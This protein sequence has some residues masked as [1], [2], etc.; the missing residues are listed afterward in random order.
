LDAA[1][2]RAGAD[3]VESGDAR[4]GIALAVVAC[5]F[6]AWLRIQQLGIQI[7]VDDEWHALHKLLHAGVRDIAT[8]FG[9]ADYS[10]PLTLYYRGLYDLGL[11]DEWSMRLPLLAAGLALLVVAPMLARGWIGAEARALLVGLLAIA[12]LPV[13]YS[14]TARPYA[15][16]CVLG[17]VAIVAFRR[18]WQEEPHARRWALVYALATIV[19]GWLHL[20]SLVFT[21]LP[22]AYYGLHALVDLASPA[23]RAAG[24]RGVRRLLGLGCATA[25]PLAALLVPPLLG[26]WN[27]LAVKTASGVP[28]WHGLWRGV[29]MLFGTGIPAV[30]IVLGGV[31]GFGLLRVGCR[32]PDLAGYLAAIAL[33][34]C[35]VILAARP[36][37]IQHQAAFARYAL[38]VL[39]VL[40]LFVAEG[41]AGLF[42]GLRVRR[43]TIVAA[44]SAGVIALMFAAGPIPDRLQTPNQFT[45]HARYAFDFAAA[46]NPYLQPNMLPGAP[47]PAFY[48]ELAARPPESVT[49]I[50]A[51]WRLESNYVPE[52]YYQPIHRQFVKVGMVGG[53]CGTRDWGEYPESATGIHL[54]N[55]VHLAAILRGE[56]VGADYLIVRPRPWTIPPDDRDRIEWPDMGACLP[57]I[58]AALGA[59]LYRDAQIIVF[60]LPGS[61]RARITPGR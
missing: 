39:P 35:V 55:A 24:A 23:R 22:F 32:D 57:T 3:G 51:P 18:W 30:G 34:G 16:T 25:L 13:H 33:V 54:A 10:I 43:A 52:A 6:G 11:L 37:W 15:L 61:N 49:V 31:A 17:F 42:E 48:R 7:L 20:V 50:E 56:P 59:P 27:A 19:A 1:R 36:A 8:H 44:G 9:R 5:A 12:P 53:V 46:E 21:L 28:T 58:R 60:G 47:M 41:T 40:L 45:G 26:D 29:L 38:P 4:P 14:R 2:R